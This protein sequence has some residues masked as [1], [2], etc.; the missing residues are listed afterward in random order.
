MI[1]CY[2]LPTHKRSVHRI[3]S[4]I[5]SYFKIEI[6]AIRTLHERRAG[7]KWVNVQLRFQVH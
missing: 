6:F 1:G 3:F 2:R 4:I 5:P 7:H